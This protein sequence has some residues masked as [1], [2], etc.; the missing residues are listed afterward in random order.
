LVVA[1]VWEGLAVS[2]L[3]AQK[4]DTEKFNVKKITRGMIKNIIKLQSETS[5]QLCKT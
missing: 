2:K 1:K 5:L 4:I 3:A